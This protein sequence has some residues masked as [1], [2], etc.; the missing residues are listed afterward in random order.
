MKVAISGSLA[1]IT[2]LLNRMALPTSEYFDDGRAEETDDHED[3]AHETVIGDTIEESRKLRKK[4]EQDPNY[5]PY[6]G[7]STPSDKEANVAVLGT[8]RLYGAEKD[9]GVEQKL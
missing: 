9:P 8:E 2:E 6:P 3:T 7:V 1:E 5:N 4:L